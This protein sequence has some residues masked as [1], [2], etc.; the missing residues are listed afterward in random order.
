MKFTSKTGV[1]CPLLSSRF[2]G[3]KIQ[4]K[5]TRRKCVFEITSWRCSNLLYFFSISK[6]L[7]QTAQPFVFYILVFLI[8][9]NVCALNENFSNKVTNLRMNTKLL[10][11][12]KW[13]KFTHRNVYIL[14]NDFAHYLKKCYGKYFYV[15]FY[16]L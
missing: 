4:K 5:E 10:C 16:P 13:N 7:A 9:K 11:Q 3:A 6:I 15:F 8:F 1:C 2:S 12:I 14:V